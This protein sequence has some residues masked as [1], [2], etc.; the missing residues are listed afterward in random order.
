MC[1]VMCLEET[2]YVYTHLKK[3]NLNAG[4][5]KTEREK[6][7][8][9]ELYEHEYS[10]CDNNTSI[11]N[12]RSLPSMCQAKKIQDVQAKGFNL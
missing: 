5:S 2:A 8:F 9:F 12:N 4:K 10:K 11:D 6:L 7:L 3:Y 1:A